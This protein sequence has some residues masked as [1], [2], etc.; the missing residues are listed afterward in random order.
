MSTFD[1]AL[2]LTPADDAFSAEVSPEWSQGRAA[3]GGLAVGLCLR[4][5]ERRVSPERSLRSALAQFVAAVEPGPARVEVTVRRV[6]KAVTQVE[7]RVVQ[8]DEPRC[9]VLASYG[10]A[11]PSLIA[12]AS[13][14][15]P[16]HP[17]PDAVERFPYVEGAAPRFTQ[18]FEYAWEPERF[19]FIGASRASLGGWIRHREPTR[20]DAASLAALVDAWPAPVLPLL[21][22]PAPASSVTWMLD[23]VATIPPG[24]FDAGRWWRFEAEAD[25]AAGGYADVTGRLWSDE[26]ALV[27]TSRQLMVEFSAH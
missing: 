21:T 26:G 12:L 16:R 27:A 4:A 11:R 13:A 19:P 6:G 20:A 1:E 22:A 25:A 10:A 8:G 18:R 14:P 23:V 24:G 2:S 9:V 7:S 17:P 15:P 5:I 3:F